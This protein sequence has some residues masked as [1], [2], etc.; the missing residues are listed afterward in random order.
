MT[1]ET[2]MTIPVEIVPATWPDFESL[3]GERGGCGGCWCMLWRRTAKQMAAGK[4][5]GNRRA[6][7]ALFDRG[8]GPGLVA[9][10]GADTVGWIQIDRRSAFH[11]L[12]TSRVLKPVDDQ[13]VWSVSCFY[14]DKRYRRG[15]LS[16]DLLNAAVDR[17]ATCGATIV[18][19]YPVDTPKEKYPAVY[20]WTGFLGTFRK[21]GFTEVA[22]RSETR[23]I[24]RKYLGGSGLDVSGA[25]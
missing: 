20:A 21:A 12:A 10:A 18:E 1:H 11:R 3:M 16:V 8:E 4:G 6:M 15:G 14:I 17:A 22:R 7:K 13:D 2:A 25:G 5:D 24:M 23:P 19:G 9:R